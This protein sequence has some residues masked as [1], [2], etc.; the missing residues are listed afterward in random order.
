M[1]ICIYIIFIYL[2]IY[3]IFIYMHILHIHIP[4]RKQYMLFIANFL[5]LYKYIYNKE[6]GRDFTNMEE[7]AK[8]RW[9]CKYRCRQVR[10]CVAFAESV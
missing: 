3:I 5:G 4:I 1:Y 9:Y 10:S 6:R 7:N 2:Y 8:S